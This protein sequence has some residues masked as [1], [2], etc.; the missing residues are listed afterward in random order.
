MVEPE[1]EDRLEAAL[2]EPGLCLIEAREWGP[3]YNVGAYAFN[4]NAQTDEIY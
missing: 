4:I 1:A 3:L 2:R